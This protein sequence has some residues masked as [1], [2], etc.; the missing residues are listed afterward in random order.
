ME[1]KEAKAQFEVWE[2][3]EKANS[4]IKDLPKGKMLEY[5]IAETKDFE[6][7]IN[8]FKNEQIIQKS[9]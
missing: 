7:E 4:K 6:E 2:W 9:S 1:T 8:N 5:I 3:K